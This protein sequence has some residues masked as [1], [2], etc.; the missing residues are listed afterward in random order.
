MYDNAERI[1][2]TGLDES[3]EPRRLRQ[4]RR[5]GRLVAGLVVGLAAV[6]LP[7][8]VAPPEAEAM[9]AYD[10]C[11]EAPVNPAFDVADPSSASVYRLYCAYFLRYPDSAGY[12]YWLDIHATGQMDLRQISDFFSASQEFVLTYSSLTNGEF[13]DLVY[14]NVMERAPDREG[15]EYWLRLMDDGRV[16]RGYLMLFFSD[17]N[18][19][20]MKTGT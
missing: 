8:T 3:L 9:A 19:F 10:N 20:R 13:I 18:E 14:R 17:S 11:R 16:T 15:Y 4:V 5:P 2:M 12:Q 7:V 6:V 1:R